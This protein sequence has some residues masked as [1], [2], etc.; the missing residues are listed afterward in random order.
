MGR[1][2]APRNGHAS[3]SSYNQGIFIRQT[4]ENVLTQGYPDLE[5]IVVGGGSTD[6]TVEIIREYESELA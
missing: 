4:L 1:T 6:E 5:L 2:R 3:L